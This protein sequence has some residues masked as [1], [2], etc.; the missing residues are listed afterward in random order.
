MY[1]CLIWF[2][3]TSEFPFSLTNLI[4]ES[5]VVDQLLGTVI[6]SVESNFII[7]LGET[8]NR[9]FQIYP[10]PLFPAF[11]GSKSVKVGSSWDIFPR[12]LSPEEPL[13]IQTYTLKSEFK[14]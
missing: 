11:E 4:W 10:S 13:S 5:V 8:V 3:F 1:T 12:G 7:S 2:K 14:T 6:Y 9:Y